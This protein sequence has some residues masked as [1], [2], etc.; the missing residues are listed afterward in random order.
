MKKFLSLALSFTLTVGLASISG[1]A[2]S[3]GR[4]PAAAPA[5]AVSTTA[6]ATPAPAPGS[7]DELVSLLPAS[8][9][10]AVVDVGR[11]FNELLPRLAG[12]SVG[13]IDKM[14]KEIQAFTTQTGI[15]PA[16]V[17]NAVLGLNLSGMQANGAVVIYGLDLDDK[18]MEAAFKAFKAEYKTS[19]YKGKPIFSVV[20]KVKP[21][22]AGP[23]S[24][25]T[26]EM[27]VASIGS[28]KLVLGD[29]S[30]VKN[31]IDAQSGEL[32]GGVKP[33]MLSALNETKASSLVRFALN[34]PDGLRQEAANQGDLFKSVST[35]KMILGTFDIANDF[36][37]SLDALMRT[38]SQKDATELEDG[39]KGLVGILRG[40]LGGGDPKMDVFG[41]LLDQIKIGSN[42]S[43]VSLAITLP[44]SLI[45][46]LTKKPE[47]KK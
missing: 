3:A 22:S 8:D 5:K 4:G 36:S 28:Q 27:A 45:D 11:A 47:E 25:K 19:D 41:Q 39:L 46:Q 29:L 40:F 13:G 20:S 15:D 14:A 30:A 24:V 37:L 6:T 26:D 44:R 12:M 43:D 2:Q 10:I 42:L 33:A 23:V 31:V 35:I 38:A 34:I 16:K 17:Q 9:L 21:P 7:I 1:R 32:K 18:M